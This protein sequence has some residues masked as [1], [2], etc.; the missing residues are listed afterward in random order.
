M[1]FG[2]AVEK[3]HHIF[4]SKWLLD[5]LYA[6][7]FCSSYTE[8]TRF[9]Q[10]SIITEDATLPGITRDQALSGM[11]SQHSP[12]T[13]TSTFTPWIGKTFSMEWESWASQLTIT[14]CL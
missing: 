6:L 12:I 10:S 3:L 11:F 8:V 2:P 5:E 13:T 7:R 1:Q 9:K 14:A 4:V